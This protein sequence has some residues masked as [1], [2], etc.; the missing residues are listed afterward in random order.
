MTQDNKLEAFLDNVEFK[1]ENILKSNKTN[2]I[3]YWYLLIMLI[4]LLTLEWYYRN[5]FGLV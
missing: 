1:E 5:K 4:S 3:S 2:L